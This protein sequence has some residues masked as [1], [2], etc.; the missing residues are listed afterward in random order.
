MEAMI[1]PPYFVPRRICVCRHRQMPPTRRDGGD[2]HIVV[3]LCPCCMHGMVF[4]L[5]SNKLGSAD[6]MGSNPPSRTMT[7]NDFATSANRAPVSRVRSSGD[8]AKTAVA[9]PAAAQI[10]GYR[11]RS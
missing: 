7:Y 6:R 9:D 1:Q 3:L 2:R 5:M 8:K 4:Q 11:A 10:V